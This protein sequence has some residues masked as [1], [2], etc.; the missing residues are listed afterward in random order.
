MA[1]LWLRPA[2]RHRCG[3]GARH[4]PRADQRGPL[5]QGV[6]RALVPRLRRAGRARGAI[7]AERGGGC[8]GVPAEHIVAAARMY[9][10]GPSTFVSGHGIDAFSAGVQ[11]FRAYHC[12]VAISGNVDRPGGNLRMR[13][14]KGFRNYSDLLHMPDSASTAATETSARSAPTA[15]RCGPARRA[16]RPPATTP[17]SIDAMLTGKPLSGARALCQRRQHPRH[18]SRTRGAPSRRCARSISWRWPRTP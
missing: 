9:A 18:L 12:L 11:T 8:T 7:H 6:R 5:R 2:R 4:D 10:D 15:S 13:T 17:P 14:P 16:G 1:D 3:A